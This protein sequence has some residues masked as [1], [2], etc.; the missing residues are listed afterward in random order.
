VNAR[1]VIT[2]PPVVTNAFA[3]VGG[4]PVVLAGSTNVFS[5]AATDPDGNS[6]TCFWDFGD[7][8]SSTTC[9]PSHAYTDCG[10]YT[11]T[12][13]AGD[14]LATNSDSLAV[15]VPCE[16][17]VTNKGTKVQAK[18]NFAKIKSDSLSFQTFVNLSAGFNVAGKV[19]TLSFG[20]EEVAFSL[21]AKG[22]GI[23]SPNTCSLKYSK[24]TGLWIFSSKWKARSCADEW[25]A[26]GLTNESI[27]KPGRPVTLPIILVIGGEPFAADCQLTYTAKLNKSGTAK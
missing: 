18:L 4:S 13:N 20:G 7:G 22:K 1:P 2:S 11:V 15:L 8:N 16:L 3:I 27:A 14:D 23:S 19:I 25:A 12:Y 26:H 5:A 17:N 21:N 6:V 24:T 9:N 10:S